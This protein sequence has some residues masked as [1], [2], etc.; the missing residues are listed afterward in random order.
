LKRS[1]K[2]ATYISRRKRGF[3]EMS[4]G[5]VTLPLCN[6]CN[7]PI[8]PAERAVHFNCPNCHETV[9]WRSEKCRKFSRRYKCL[10]CGFE[11]P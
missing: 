2:P 7:R 5:T 6:S 9:I 8:K 4:Q 1:D 3:R 11:G 10:N